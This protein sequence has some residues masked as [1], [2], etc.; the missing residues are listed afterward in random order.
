MK[1]VKREL[2]YLVRKSN[3]KKL[4]WTLR[5]RFWIIKSN[6]NTKKYIQL[7]LKSCLQKIYVKL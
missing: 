2:I 6:N 3:P 5:L 1:T 7:T 4:N